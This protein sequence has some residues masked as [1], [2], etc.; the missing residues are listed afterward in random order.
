VTE[1]TRALLGGPL[2]W[3]YLVETSVR[4]AVA[5]LLH[6]GLERVGVA[7]AV[8]SAARDELAD[9]ARGAAERHRRLYAVTREIAEAFA[10]A[11]VDA[12]ALKD[13]DLAA[14]LYPAP[15]LRPLGDLDLLVRPG[16]YP[17]A[18]RCLTRAGFR[19][20]PQTGPMVLEYGAGVNFRRA[21]DE[22]WV[23]LQWGVAQREWD[24]AGEAVFAFDVE[25]FWDRAAPAALEGAEMLCAS[26]EDML[27]HLCLHL[28][29]H[30]YGELVLLY[31]IA[32]L[33]E[34]RGAVID[35]DALAARA[36]AQGAGGSLE[37]AMRMVQRLYGTPVPDQVLDL[38]PSYVEARLHLPLF[39]SLGPLHQSIDEIGAAADP[40]SAELSRFEAVARQHRLAASQLCRELDA[41]IRAV[42]DAGSGPAVVEARPSPMLLPDRAEAIFDEIRLL[43]PP[44]GAGAAADALAGRGYAAA[45]PGRWQRP[46]SQGSREPAIVGGPVTVDLRVVVDRGPG[47]VP[48]AEASDPSMRAVATRAV[49]RRPP[50]PFTVDVRVVARPREAL[51]AH[52][53]AALDG[54]GHERLFEADALLHLLER[55]RGSLDWDRVV[56]VAGAADGASAGR[57][58][59]LAGGLGGREPGLEAA[60]GRLAPAAGGQRALEWARYGESELTRHTA[61]RGPV[62]FLFALTHAEGGSERAEL[63]RGLVRGRGGRPARARPLARD[64]ARGLVALARP[65]PAPARSLA[66]WIEPDALLPHAEGAG[67]VAAAPAAPAAGADR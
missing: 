26:D 16:R 55:W 53:A 66:H 19:P 23:D 22:V 56:E 37:R 48:P 49:R 41:L 11:G 52:L 64:L 51:V 10:G 31:D 44:E 6:H 27:L 20:L 2:R 12:I 7:D 40:P 14:R 18:A 33:C 58:L 42:C 59:A 9:L 15:G 63:L 54:A 36:A 57:G 21:E 38:D 13:L 29:G 30:R 65:A 28:E 50:R 8:P 60:V 46:L 32:L 35:W 25:G 5:P 17:A 39:A 4:H 43:V 3:D 1:R 45:G 47:A 67:S 61:L 34:R 62:L 24:V